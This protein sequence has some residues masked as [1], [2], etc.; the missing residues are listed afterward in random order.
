MPAAQPPVSKFGIY[1][2]KQTCYCVRINSP[3]WLPEEKEGWVMVTPEVNATILKIREE[4]VKKKLVKA[5]DKD[6]VV[7]EPIKA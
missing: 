2:N 7:W 6:K 5:D 3:Y 1:M 4:A